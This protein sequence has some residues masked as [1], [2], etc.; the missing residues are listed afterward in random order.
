MSKD[1]IFVLEGQVVELLPNALF[2][3][4]LENNS[5]ILCHLNGKMRINNINIR[6]LDHVQIEVSIYDISKGRIIFRHK[7]PMSKSF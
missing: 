3:V 1:D 6:L 4:K 5:E 7:N 2:K